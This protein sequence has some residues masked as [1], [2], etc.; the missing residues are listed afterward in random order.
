MAP[1]L[2]RPNLTPLQLYRHILREV[3]YLAPAIR[4]T[5]DHF[6]RL[7]FHQNRFDTK[8]GRTPRHL[9]TAWNTLRSLRSAN[10]GDKI[11]LFELLE[12]GFGRAGVRRHRLMAEFTPAQAPADTEVL[13]AFIAKAQTAP[14][15]DKKSTS[16]RFFDRWDREKLLQLLRSQRDQQ[17]RSGDAVSWHG[18]KVKA[19]DPEANIPDQTIWGKPTPEVVRQTKRASWWRRAADK[20]MPP[21][22]KGEW[23]LLE[24]LSDGAQSVEA[25]WIVPVRRSRAVLLAK[26]STESAAPA[27]KWED[28]ADHATATVEASKS[29][30]QQRRTGAVDHGPYSVGDRTR[31]ITPRF[32]ER[33]YR[34]IWATTPKMEQNPKNLKHSFVWGSPSKQRLPP[35]TAHQLAIFDGVDSKGQ[36]VAKPK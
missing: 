10:N 1:S 25:E 29:L 21:L 22:A 30:L 15:A 19:L 35:A 33:A 28:Y 6:I 23:E 3:S 9:K 17:E 26:A 7:R 20:V 4:P 18:S 34:R 27:W 8:S 11:K 12:K 2:P 16:P 24:R 31:T 14:S 5:F 36:K 13:E 32:Y